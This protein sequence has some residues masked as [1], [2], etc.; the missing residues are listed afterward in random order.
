[1]AFSQSCYGY[2][3]AGHPDADSLACLLYLIPHSTLF[4]YFSLMISLSQGA[5]R[6]MFTKQDLDALSFPDL[7]SLPTAT[8]TVLRKFAH[9]LEH[10]ARKPGDEIDAL[11]FRLYRLDDETQQVI[12]DTLFSAA[13]YRRA[14][15]D[16]LKRTTRDSRAP[17][18]DALQTLLT[19]FFEIC[20]QRVAVTE[21]AFQA[22]HV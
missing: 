5:D 3:C 15:R 2:S 21:P 9:R 10:D 12:R 6:M 11:I 19:P 13:A 20:G 18:R 17:F 1:M 22:L 8:K 16:A 14:G 4:R 7:A